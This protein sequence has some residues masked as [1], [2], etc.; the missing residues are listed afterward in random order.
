MPSQNELFSL[1]RAKG[2]EVLTGGVNERFSPTVEVKTA[3]KMWG[4]AVYAKG[5]GGHEPA[6]RFIFTL[7]WNHIR[8]GNLPEKMRVKAPHG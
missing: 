4:Y 5:A 1:P 2:I 3:G 7:I 6:E 8:A